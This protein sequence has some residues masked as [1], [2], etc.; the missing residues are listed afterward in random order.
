M[1]SSSGDVLSLISF[2]DSSRG[3]NNDYDLMM[4]LMAKMARFQRMEEDSEQLQVPDLG[5][6]KD[7]CESLY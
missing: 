5:L 3:V 7:L 2:K 4:E 1:A 6:K